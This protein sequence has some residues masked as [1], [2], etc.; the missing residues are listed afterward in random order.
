MGFVL[1]LLPL[2]EGTQRTTST[3]YSF[4]TE[5]FFMA[6][7]ALDLGFRTVQEKFVKL[8]QEL[9]RLQGAYR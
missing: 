3:S 2:Q 6:H 1:H 9:S 5:I 8:N 7:K 4:S